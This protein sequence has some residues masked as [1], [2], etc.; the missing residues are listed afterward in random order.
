ML[1]RTEKNLKD[2]C[3]PT[4]ILQ[5]RTH[6]RHQVT[7]YRAGLTWSWDPHLQKQVD[8]LQSSSLGVRM[9]RKAQRSGDTKQTITPYS[10][11]SSSLMIFLE[12]KSAGLSPPTTSKLLSPSQA[13]ATSS[14]QAAWPETWKESIE[15][16]LESNGGRRLNI[17]VNSGTCEAHQGCPSPAEPHF[18]PS[19]LP[20]EA[21][22]SRVS[23]T[24]PGKGRN[25]FKPHTEM[26]TTQGLCPLSSEWPQHIT[27]PSCWFQ[28]TNS[29]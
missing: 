11:T 17:T 14:H 10:I 23:R 26:R 27:A 18:L 4:V 9:A 7:N 20:L 13:G 12:T 5:G 25:S 21:L 16:E 22:C 28:D 29:P 2:Q 3:V 24:N 19:L 15:V 6:V 8:Y 1:N